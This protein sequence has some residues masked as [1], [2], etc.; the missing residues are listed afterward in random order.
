MILL[1]DRENFVKNGTKSLA[2]YKID[3]TWDPFKHIQLLIL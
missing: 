2:Y 1:V 3:D